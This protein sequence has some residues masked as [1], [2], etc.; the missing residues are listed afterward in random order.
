LPEI[1]SLFGLL[2]D[3]E[4]RADVS[5]RAVLSDQQWRKPFIFKL[6]WQFTVKQRGCERAE[7]DFQKKRQKN[8]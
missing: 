4:P 2:W 8:P 3:T 6:L 5:R 1:D 7:E